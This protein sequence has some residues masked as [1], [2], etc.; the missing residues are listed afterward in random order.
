MTADLGTDLSSTLCIAGIDPGKSGAYA[1]Y[2]PDYPDRVLAED[3]PVAGDRVDAV[4]LANAIKALAP[5]FVIVESVHSMPRQ[6]VASSFSFG[7]SFGTV[8]GV[9]G[10]L[11]I[12]YRLVSPTVWKKHFSLNS[13]KEKSR[14]EAL[15]LWPARHDLFKRRRDEGRSE[16][17]LLAKY[18]AETLQQFQRRVA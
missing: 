3:M 2:F 8:L 1:F 10:A 14:A 6:G 11:E 16:A 12:P 18:G 15:R 7:A 5:D 13:D 4:S 9:L 17:A